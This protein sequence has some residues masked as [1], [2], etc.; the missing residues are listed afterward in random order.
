MN[1]IGSYTP[2]NFFAGSYPII[3]DSGTIASNA[4]IV[5]HAP[6]VMGDSGITTAAADSLDKLIG[7]SADVPSG[8][9]VVYYMTG[10]YF[11]E[12]LVLPQGV[13]AADLKP[14]FRKLGIFL[15]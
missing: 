4:A 1:E 6:L 5:K 15:R 8:D 10:E 11:A 3:T 9:K 12:A 13:T 14:A 7:I 2:D